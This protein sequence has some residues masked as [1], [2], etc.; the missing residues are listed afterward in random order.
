MEGIHK[1]TARYFYTEATFTCYF[2]SQNQY[3]FIFGKLILW[4]LQLNNFKTTFSSRFDELRGDFC[5][6]KNFSKTPPK[7]HFPF[8]TSERT[9]NFLFKNTP[10]FSLPGSNKWGGIKNFFEIGQ[11]WVCILTPFV[12]MSERSFFYGKIIK[13]IKT[14]MGLFYQSQN[15]QKNIQ[16]LM[17]QMSEWLQTKLSGNRCVLSDVLFQKKCQIRTKQQRFHRFGIRG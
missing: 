3:I 17:P 6:F 4:N 10:I 9:F 1:Y 8:Q 13:E 11:I 7:N 2:V 5:F 16:R 15:R 14:G 12:Q